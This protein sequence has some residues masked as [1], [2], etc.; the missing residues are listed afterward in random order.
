MR[1]QSYAG[2]EAAVREFTKT[3][4]DHVFHAHGTP[5]QNG[6]TN[7][8]Q[9]AHLME[10]AATSGARSIVEVGFNI[11]FS[12]H[13]FLAASDEISV[14]SFDLSDN[15][16]SAIAKEVIDA[17]FPGRHD[18]ILGD[19]RT[20]VPSFLIERQMESEFDMAFI[21]GGHDYEVV[22]ADIMNCR[23]ACR[24]GAV[25][26][27]D[28]LTPWVPWGFGPTEAWNEAI[29]QGVIESDALYRDGERCDA[30]DGPADRLWGVGT[31][32]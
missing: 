14:V 1:S 28:D 22:T 24:Q 29:A 3:I 32:Q 25:V 9:L 11:G 7:G 21:D 23:L 5:M 4:F 13:A 26:I 12:S 17:R 6:F 10:I 19:S 27:V 31:Y 20:S 30:I 15:N 2:R 16:A 8:V 18:L